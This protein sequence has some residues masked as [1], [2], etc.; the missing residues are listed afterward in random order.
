MLVRRCRRRVTYKDILLAKR[1]QNKV[2][3]SSVTKRSTYRADGVVDQDGGACQVQRR[4][5]LRTVGCHSFRVLRASTLLVLRSLV[6]SERLP[7]DDSSSVEDSG[8]INEGPP[9]LDAGASEIRQEHYRLTMRECQSHAPDFPCMCCQ[10]SSRWTQ[11]LLTEPSHPGLVCTVRGVLLSKG[12][13]TEYFRVP[14]RER[15]T[16]NAVCE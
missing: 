2:I 12:N 15:R 16:I 5:Q 10:A 1:L 3:R 11:L 6:G 9:R 13:P 14:A 4:R 8:S 7:A